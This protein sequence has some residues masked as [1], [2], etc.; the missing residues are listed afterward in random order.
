MDFLEEYRK[1]YRINLDWNEK[2]LIPYFPIEIQD[3]FFFNHYGIF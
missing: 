2:K 3:G 1:Q